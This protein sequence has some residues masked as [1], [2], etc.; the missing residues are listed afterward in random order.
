LEKPFLFFFVRDDDGA[1]V[2]QSDLPKLRFGDSGVNP[3]HP[4]AAC[5]G[6]VARASADQIAAAPTPAGARVRTG[7]DRERCRGLT[8]FLSA[9]VGRGEEFIG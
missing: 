4:P 8:G 6:H 7:V 5:R 2:F 1:R 9:E 3:T